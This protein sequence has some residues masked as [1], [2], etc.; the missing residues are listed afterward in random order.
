MQAIGARQGGFQLPARGRPDEAVARVVQR[1]DQ[2]PDRAPPAR[3][4]NQY[5]PEPVEVQLRHLARRALGQAHRD[6]APAPTAALDEAPQRVV[7][8]R[9]ATFVLG[10]PVQA[11]G[12]LCGVIP[13]LRRSQT[14]SRV[15]ARCVRASPGPPH[16]TTSR[17]FADLRAAGPMRRQRSGS[18]SCLR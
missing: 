5:E 4:W 7:R 8:D 14:K 17:S 3:L 15:S 18:Q 9:A 1:H 13:K 12:R 10:D 16:G 2:R 6:C 11:G